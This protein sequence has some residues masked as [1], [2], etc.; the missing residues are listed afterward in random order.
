[1]RSQWACP[2]GFRGAVG[3]HADV[4]REIRR[5]AL[6]DAA[7]KLRTWR[8][9]GRKMTWDTASDVVMTM[10]DTERVTPARNVKE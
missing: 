6:E 5:C 7:E 8:G 10:A 4:C 1:M 2:H 9:S 3:C